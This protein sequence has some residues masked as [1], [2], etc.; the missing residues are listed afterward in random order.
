MPTD[1]LPTAM[2]ELCMLQAKPII[3]LIENDFVPVRGTKSD[4]VIWLDRLSAI[5][6][7]TQVTV[8]NGEVH[9]CQPV[10]N[11]MWPILSRACD[12]Y[13]ADLRIME[14][15]CRCLRFAIR[16]VG[17]Q[18]SYL[19]RPLVEQITRLYGTYKHSCFLYLGSILVD[20]YASDNACIP[21]LVD[22]LSAFLKPTFDR[23]QE[24]NGLKNHPDTVDD[25]FR[26]STRFLQRAPVDF[27]QCPAMPAIVQCALL[28]CN[29]DHRDANASVMKFFCDL[30]ITGRNHESR[31][32]Y[33]LRRTLVQSLLQQNAQLLVNNLLYASVFY[34][35]S[36]MLSD[37]ADV[38]LEL[39]NADRVSFSVWLENAINALPTQTSSGCISITPN[40]CLDFHVSVTRYV[41]SFNFLVIQ[42]F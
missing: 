4:P 1:Q 11:E 38:L 16:C 31:N 20:E 18:A 2:R 19:V 12:K 25:F 42:T 9:P 6:R 22:M 14:R 23:L 30:I 37:V 29:L 3:E 35:H 15:C 17:K 40:Q 41:N 21:I 8:Q 5:F 13:Q 7:N 27:L 33:E 28:A 10:I 26:L 24:E 36:Y 39:Q 32:D 34:L